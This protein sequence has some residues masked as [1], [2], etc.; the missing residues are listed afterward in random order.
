MG[1]QWRMIGRI[2]PW[3][4][5]LIILWPLRGHAP[6]H[7]YIFNLRKDNTR[8]ISSLAYSEVTGL[9]AGT[10][11][12]LDYRGSALLLPRVG[13]GHRCMHWEKDRSFFALIHLIDLLI[14]LLNDFT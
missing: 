2:P 9:F 10:T 3:A 1:I 13:K 8:M 14:C 6:I 4:A 12:N 11:L 5:C 7:P